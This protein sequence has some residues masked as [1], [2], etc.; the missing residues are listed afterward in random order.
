MSTNFQGQIEV[1]DFYQQ[2][3]YWSSVKMTH[4]QGFSVNYIQFKSL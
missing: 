4:S 2:G 3:R 1:G